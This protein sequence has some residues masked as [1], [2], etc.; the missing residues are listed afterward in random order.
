MQRGNPRFTL[1]RKRTLFAFLPF[2]AACEERWYSSMKYALPFV[3]VSALASVFGGEFS[4]RELH[5]DL[6]NGPY[7][8]SEIAADFGNGGAPVGRDFASI[9]D[10]VLQI[11]FKAGK[12]VTE[13]G[14]GLQTRVPEAEACELSFRIRYPEDFLAGLHGKQMGMSGGAGYDGGRGE[15]A[16]TNGDGWSSRI[17]FD[18][19]KDSIRNSLYVYHVGMAGKY[20]ES[21]KAGSYHL[22]RGQWHSIRVRATSQSTPE[23][24]DGRI[25]V[26]CD[27]E[28][29]IDAA[30]LRL[31]AK[32]AGL[33]VNRVRAEVFPGGGGAFPDKDYVVEVDDFCWT[34]LTPER[35]VAPSPEVLATPTETPTS[36]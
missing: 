19:L 33:A 32:Q 31:A 24:S 18:A 10:G 6:E 7:T 21:L 8:A 16:R 27:D 30:G 15:E 28:K 34:A 2:A 22:Q 29:K 5:F 3:F 36:R 9:K 26:W 12:K 4:Q 17:Q 11:T 1:K 35:S 20:G 13:T 14:L 23:A 25:E